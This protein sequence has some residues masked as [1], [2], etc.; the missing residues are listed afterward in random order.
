MLRAVAATATGLAIAVAADGCSSYGSENAPA[1]VYVPPPELAVPPLSGPAPAAKPTP[2][3]PWDIGGAPRV[4][5]SISPTGVTAKPIGPGP[6]P[7]NAKR[8]EMSQRVAAKPSLRSLDDEPL[9]IP[10][11]W[12][13]HALRLVRES[14]GKHLLTY[15]RSYVAIVQGDIVERLVDLDPPNSGLS[16]D[17]RAAAQ[18]EGA[19]YA[20]GVLFV[21]RST[22]SKAAH[23]IAVDVAT[24]DVR[25]RSSPALCS[26]PIAVLGDY[27]LTD[28][29]PDARA[30][31]MMLRRNI[32]GLVQSISIDE[33]VL[34][35]LVDTPA[36][37]RVITKSY[38][39]T[40]RLK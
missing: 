34:A 7:A 39:H 25:W 36:Q 22:K 18:V 12:D 31:V 17:E 28:R 40:F 1:V 32:G 2:S 15:G 3:M 19:A 11:A 38:E 29:S 8:L 24:G 13:G 30:R 4:E 20:D 10:R 27:V 6:S 37:A 23:V 35:I 21:C 16:E 5:A 33:P 14:G 9:E 26:G